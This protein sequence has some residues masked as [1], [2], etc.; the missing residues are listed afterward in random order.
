LI[1]LLLLAATLNRPIIPAHAGP[2]RIDPDVE[3]LAHARAD[4]GD[5]R[6]FDASGR[7]VPYL[8]IPPVS[9]EP[10]WT[11]GRVLPVASTKTTSGF[12]LDLGSAHK[13]DRIRVEGIATPFLK[14]ARLEGS[15]DRAHWTLLGDATLFELPD[16][17]LRDVEI[18]F[19]AGD[20]RYLR[21]TWDDRNSAVVSNV[22]T[23]SARL[24]DAETPPDPVR[25]PLTF[26]KMSSEPQKS[27]YHVTLPGA[28]LPVDAIE[29]T[30]TNGEVFR[31][32][33]V[34]EPHLEGGRI[35]PQPL[36]SS[37]LKRAERFGGVAADMAVPVQHPSGVDLQLIVDDGNNPPLALTGI[38]AKL[39]PLPWI[40]FESADGSPVTARYGDTQLT[41]PQYDLEASRSTIARSTP[42]L[43]RWEGT[44]HTSPNESVETTTIASF[45]GAAVD[46]NDFRYAR[47][48]PPAP[49][50]VTRLALDADVLSHSREVADVRIVDAKNQQVPYIV[51]YTASPLTIAMKVPER[52]AEGRSSVYAFDLPYDTLPPGS[53]IVFTTSAHV[54]QRQVAWRQAS[55]ER[56]GRD[57]SNIDNATWSSSQPDLV[58]PPLIFGLPHAKRVELVIDEGDNAP[59][60]VTSAV[61]EIPGVALRF[62]NPGSPLT[63]LYGSAHA[64]APQYDL[65]LLAPRVLGEPARDIALGATSATPEETALD[66]KI[67][68]VALA[69]ATLILL[70]ILARLLRSRT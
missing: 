11:D 31:K 17:K 37:T 64:A 58:P 46:R 33:Y 61:M 5:L 27:L 32:A 13:I 54:F 18:E 1:P 23:V 52:T 15:G 36:G 44:T 48:I 3:L 66:A 25:V 10:R 41:A 21:V 20:Y 63:L 38:N 42:P 39:A 49:V 55:D 69:L 65:A 24:H 60:P 29:A 50:G 2:N 53:R 51:E 28:Q 4:L 70:A 68:W 30:V 9:R 57:A 35:I 67:F 12:E 7:E 8:V 34:F 14:R 26:R 19:A 45:R 43:A 62:Y 22:G 40:W 16:E 6:L 59:L 47:A 56:R